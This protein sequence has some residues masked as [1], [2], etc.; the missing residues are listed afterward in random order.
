MKS[1]LQDMK[2]LV[3]KLPNKDVKLGL[4]LL[5][6]RQFDTLLE[7]VESAI[8]RTKKHQLDGKNL[9]EYGKVDVFSLVLLQ[10]QIESYIGAITYEE[11][12]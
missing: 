3:L 11:E 4:K 1:K 5:S 6:T 8:E 7:L 10:L 9:K 12:P 2:S